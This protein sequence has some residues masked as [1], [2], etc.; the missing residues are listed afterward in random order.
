MAAV[1]A[2]LGQLV[3]LIGL[4]LSLRLVD[5]FGGVPIYLPHPQRVKEHSPV[6]QVIGVEAMRNLASAWPMTHVTIPR[7]AAYLRRQRNAQLREDARTMS[8]PQLARKY[9][10]ALRTVER[11]LARADDDAELEAQDTQRSLFD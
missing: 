10:M 11:I 2:P 3:D 5:N 9:D 4:P 7:G 1:H 6:A 8:Q